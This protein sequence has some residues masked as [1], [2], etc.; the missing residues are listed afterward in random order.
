MLTNHIKLTALPPDEFDH[1]IWTTGYR[2]KPTASDVSLNSAY[3][4]PLGDT[5]AAMHTLHYGG[6]NGICVL[7]E[8][9]QPMAPHILVQITRVATVDDCEVQLTAVLCNALGY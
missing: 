4:Y 8:I 9:L 7:N 6:R 3:V 5:V 2:L 1:S